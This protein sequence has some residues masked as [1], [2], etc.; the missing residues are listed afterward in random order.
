[1]TVLVI[2]FQSN[3]AFQHIEANHG[4]RMPILSRKSPGGAKQWPRIPG[5]LD[6]IVT[7]HDRPPPGVAKGFESFALSHLS[8]TRDRRM[9]AGQDVFEPC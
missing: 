1:M 6:P 9:K 5:L 3:I 8:S 2:S 7:S 4:L